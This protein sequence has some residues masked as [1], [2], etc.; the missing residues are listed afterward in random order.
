MLPKARTLWWLNT[1]LIVGWLALIAITYWRMELRF[2]TPAARP[3]GAALLNPDMQP[4]APRLHLHTDAGERR[5]QGQFTLLNFWSPNCACSR[6]MEP[7]MRELVL[8]F[9]PRGVQFITVIVLSDPT[10]NGAKALRQW[11]QRGIPTPALVDA[12][13]KLARAFGV[14]AAPAAVIVDPQGRI[15]FVGAY[16][17]GRYCNN[18]QTAYAKLALQALLV[19]KRPPRTHTPFY[20]CQT[21]PE[22]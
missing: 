5:L 9:A 17:I 12:G 7:H 13:G 10:Q 21:P 14:W 11:Q 15:R 19:G 16:N 20:G 2:F 3:A 18:E 22:P 1:L 4:P 8:Q 6:F